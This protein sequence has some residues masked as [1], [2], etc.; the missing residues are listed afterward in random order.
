MATSLS[1]KTYKKLFGRSSF[2]VQK[3]Y[4]G[5]DHLLLVD[6]QYREEYRRFYYKDIAGIVVRNT[7][8]WKVCNWIFGV[9]LFLFLVGSLSSSDAKP[10]F[11]IWFVIVLLPFLYNLLRGQTVQCAIKTVVRQ[12]VIHCI[13]RKSKAQKLINQVLPLIQEAQQASA[14]Q[15]PA[16]LATSPFDVGNSP[17]STPPP[18]L[19]TSGLKPPPIPGQSPVVRIPPVPT[20]TT[21]S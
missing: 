14:L 16:P 3:L 10:A 11:I 4:R 13:S 5:V 20:D 19:G 18:F 15:E 2:S 8:T 1:A 6:G 9:L 21:P 17:T 7:A 12:E